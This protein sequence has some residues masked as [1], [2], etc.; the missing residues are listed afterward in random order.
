MAPLP[1]IRINTDQFGLTTNII[2]LTMDFEEAGHPGDP[3][4]IIGQ[5]SGATGRFTSFIYQTLDPGNFQQFLVLSNW[6]SL[7]IA[8]ENLLWFNVSTSVADSG[9]NVG[10]PPRQVGVDCDTGMC[11]DLG[12]GGTYCSMIEDPEYTYTGGTP[13]DPDPFPYATCLPYPGPNCEP[14]RGPMSCPV[15]PWA[16]PTVDLTPDMCWRGGLSA[17]NQA[18]HLH[19]P[20]TKIGV[21]MP[22]IAATARGMTLVLPLDEPYASTVESVGLDSGAI[23][24]SKHRRGQAWKITETF[25][26]SSGKL[27]RFEIVSGV[28]QVLPGE[29]FWCDQLPQPASPP[30]NAN[31]KC[32]CPLE[33]QDV[34]HA[35][36]PKAAWIKL[37]DFSE[38][39]GP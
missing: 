10:D 18:A 3:V 24:Y 12:S 34:V 28:L 21:P 7:F 1:C 23:Y 16:D 25:E 8:G 37:A 22:A 17:A 30:Y 29:T 5:T 15:F 9:I 6:S 11:P 19:R 27:F 2:D 32:R 35:S 4:I 14:M 26:D 38:D 20:N 36:T 31:V 33:Y 13:D 39:Y